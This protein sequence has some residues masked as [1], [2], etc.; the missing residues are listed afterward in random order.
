M[1]GTNEGSRAHALEPFFSFP[2]CPREDVDDLLLHRASVEVHLAAVT[3]GDQ[4]VNH[5]VKRVVAADFYVLSGLDLRA[6]LA[7]DD[8][9]WA[10]RRAVR[11]LHSEILRS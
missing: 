3:E 4:A 5:G 10:C 9:T 8:H 1:C 2:L 6:A 11:K 7:D